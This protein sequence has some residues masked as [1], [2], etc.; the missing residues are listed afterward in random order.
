MSNIKKCNFCGK[1]QSDVK[2]LIYHEG[3]GIC[4]ECIELCNDV[5]YEDAEITK[6]KDTK[7]NAAMTPKAIVE[8]FGK[9]IVNQEET[10]RTLAVGVFKHLTRI[11]NPDLGIEK[12][13]IIITGPSGC[14]K[15]HFARTIAKM[16]DVPFAICDATSL[17]AAGYVG[18]DVENVLERLYLAAD[19][20]VEAAERGIIFIDEIDK[21]ASNKIGP[22]HST[23]KDVGGESVQQGL[24]KIVEGS[25]VFIQGSVGKRRN[26]ER[27][28]SI[29]INT[30]NILFIVSGAFVGISKTGDKI[31]QVDLQK[32]GL[33]PEFVG[34]FPVVAEVVPLNI[35]ELT[36]ILTVPENS[37]ITQSQKLFG[38]L[39]NT[40]V[41][42]GTAL[43][44]IAEKALVLGTGARGLKSIVEEVLQ[45]PTF[46]LADHSNST[47][48]VNDDLSHSWT[49]LVKSE[50]PKATFKVASDTQL[51]CKQKK[52]LNK[53]ARK[54]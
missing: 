16:L 50:K 13:N 23:G 39:G 15:T 27:E 28:A 31:T 25:D 12:S 18:D 46:D 48:T 30:S 22:S 33:I 38:A 45:D 43:N 52:L 36:N 35:K 6:N 3:V 9:H 42:T 20:N 47:C 44:N 17:T 41:F 1:S 4:N 2:K 40:L 24:L 14:G 29:K 7:V 19:G 26:P 11:K 51:S 49:K 53:K 8:F 32:F 10:K 34:R 21:I 37:I 5:I 54:S